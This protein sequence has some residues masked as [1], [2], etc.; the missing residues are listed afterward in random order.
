VSFYRDLL[1]F[2]LRAQWVEGAYLEA[3]ALWLCLSLDQVARTRPH[4]DYTHIALDVASEDFAALSQ[5]V[6]AVAPLWK[7]NRSEGQSLYFLDPTVTNSNFTSAP[8]NPVSRTIAQT[9]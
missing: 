9:P 2:S 8:L 6:R 1:G 3:G 5:R 4:P 7:E